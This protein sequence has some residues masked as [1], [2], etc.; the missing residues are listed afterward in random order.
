MLN[1]PVP[2][3]RIV[4]A[5]AARLFAKFSDAPLIV[6]VTVALLL[7]TIA[8]S[9]K[10]AAKLSLDVYAV[11][12]EPLKSSSVVL[13]LTGMKFQLVNWS[14]LPVIGVEVVPPPV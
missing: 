7:S 13:P 10:P 2:F 6:S 3:S 9:V 12:P 5:A 8:L 14:Q 1:A 4:G 11:D